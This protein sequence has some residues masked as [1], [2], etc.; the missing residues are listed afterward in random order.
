M[1]KIHIFN[2]S[3]KNYFPYIYNIWI[4]IVRRKNDHPQMHAAANTMGKEILKYSDLKWSEMVYSD[5]SDSMLL[6]ANL[7]PPTNVMFLSSCIEPMYPLM[8]FL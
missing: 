7:Q 4:D 8:T 1:F 3:I 2:K 6:N 5:L